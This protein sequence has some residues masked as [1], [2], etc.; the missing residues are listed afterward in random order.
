MIRLVVADDHKLLRD[1]VVRLLELEEDFKVVGQAD[2]GE[3]AVLL[4]ERLQPDVA[5]LDV[6]MPGEGGISAAREIVTRWPAV[7]VVLLTMHDEDEMVFEGLAAGA[8]SYL[9][10]DCS[11]EELV[12]TIR[13]VAAGETRLSGS[14]LDRVLT[15]FRKLKQQ[16]G[17]TPVAPNLLSPREQEVL[18]GL[19]RGQSNKQIARDLGIDMTTVKTHLHRVYEKLGVSDRTQAAIMALQN[20]WFAPPEA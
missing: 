12:G 7:R 16:G 19:V 5:V 1:G 3:Q 18:G 6:R 2:T 8:A 9:L 15:E 10:K 4:V 14:P 11:P 20:G 13:A 17:P